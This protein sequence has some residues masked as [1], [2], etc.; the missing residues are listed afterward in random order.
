MLDATRLGAALKTA[1]V[2]TGAMANNAQATSVCNAIASAIITEI[3]TNAIV[4]P[5]GLPT[6][7]TAPPSG[8]PVTG[9]GVVQ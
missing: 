9:T 3:T 4:S 5:A 2:A 1:L 7:L 6:P 8:G